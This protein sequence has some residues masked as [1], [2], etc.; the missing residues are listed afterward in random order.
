MSP[1]LPDSPSDLHSIGTHSDISHDNQTSDIS[2][3][4]DKYEKYIEMK[5]NLYLLQSMQYNKNRDKSQVDPEELS[6]ELDERLTTK[7]NERATKSS[8]PIRRSVSSPESY[9]RHTT[10]MLSTPYSPK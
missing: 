8:P 2:N 1:S 3:G 10:S 6:L 7:K 5:K 9:E 4:R